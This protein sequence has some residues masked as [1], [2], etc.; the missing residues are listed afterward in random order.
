MHLDLPKKHI[1]Y[2]SLSLCPFKIAE[3]Q[4]LLMLLNL[5]FWYSFHITRAE[6]LLVWLLNFTLF[7]AHEKVSGQ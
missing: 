2:W 4:S 1:F 5:C 7:E 6:F 3:L